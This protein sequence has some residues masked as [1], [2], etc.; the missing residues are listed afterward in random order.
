MMGLSLLCSS[1]TP[2]PSQSTGKECLVC[3]DMTLATMQ[4]EVCR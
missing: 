3:D 2:M 4:K 1:S